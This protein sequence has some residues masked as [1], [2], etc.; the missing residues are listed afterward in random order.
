MKDALVTEEDSSKT[1]LEARATY[2]CSHG[3]DV[4]LDLVVAS[5]VVCSS[6]IEESDEH[7]GNLALVLSEPQRRENAIGKDG[8]ARRKW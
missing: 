7:S 4:S 5:R 1:C 6:D 3:I 8:G 2:G